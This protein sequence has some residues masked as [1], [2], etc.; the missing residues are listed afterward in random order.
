MFNF[1]RR[2]KNTG[3]SS[4]NDRLTLT[5]NTISDDIGLMKQWISHLHRRNKD[6]EDS[7]RNHVYVTKDDVENLKNWIS[8]LHKHN[9]E[10]KES[11]KGLTTNVIDIHKN[12]KELFERLARV[13]E[14]G[15]V[16][17]RYVPES[18]PIS[19]PIK[20][21][22]FEENMIKQIKSNR[23]TYVIS[24]MLSLI[25]QSNLSTKQV[26]RIIVNEKN[27][28][29]RTAFY[30]YLKELKDKREVEQDRKGSKKVLVSSKRAK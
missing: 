22:K 21:T 10:L 29:G 4:L 7:H 17:T 12:H 20:R 30:S 9:E 18:E 13:E 27:L 2:N 3:I 28:C 11:V 15:S 25:E 16:R 26:E 8:Y 19:E 24:H 5:F 23:K 1:L 14:K 6:L